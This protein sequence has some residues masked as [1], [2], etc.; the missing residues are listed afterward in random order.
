MLLMKHLYKFFNH[1]DTPWVQM[2]W[3]AYY[4]DRLPSTASQVGSFWWHDVCCL[5]TKFRGILVCAPGNGESVLFW[6]DHWQDELLA[7]RYARLFSFA[8]NFDATL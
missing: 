6:K 5:L 1:T 4:Q 2:M 8:L 7:I 3:Q